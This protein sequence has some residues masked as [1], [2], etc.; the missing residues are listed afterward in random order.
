V[1]TVEEAVAL[2]RTLGHLDAAVIKGSR[3]V[4][5]DE[6]VRAYGEAECV[7]APAATTPV[8]HA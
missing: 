4:R 3:A 6:V 8:T 7:P 2:L 1:H 5:L